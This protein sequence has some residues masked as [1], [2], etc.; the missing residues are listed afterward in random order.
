MTADL[1]R[2]ALNLATLFVLSGSGRIVRVNSPDGDRGPRAILAGCAAGTLVRVRQDLD[3]AAAREIVA[4]A[5][6]QAPWCDVAAPPACLP[7]VVAVLSRQAPAAALELAVIYGLPNNLR[8]ETDGRLVSGDEAEGQRLFDRLARGMPPALLAA[9]FPSVDHLWPPW[10][11]AI[12]GDEVAALAFA[13]RLGPSGAEVG[14]YTLA[15]FRGRGLA[16]AV[17]AGW[18][19]LASLADRELFYSTRAS[20]LS[21]RRVAARLGLTPL[22]ASVW[23]T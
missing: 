16:A 18:S 9:G 22:G 8:Y 10:C 21:S 12:V 3:E 20:N 2:L 6:E 14:V 5:G 11:A 19:S 1:D 17:T 7:R 13:A 4:L 15:G 23:V